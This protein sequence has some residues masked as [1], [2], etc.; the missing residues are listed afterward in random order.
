MV[1]DCTVQPHHG[2]DDILSPGN[3]QSMKEDV[4]NW[5]LDIKVSWNT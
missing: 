4:A 2:D 3:D 1:R 5:R